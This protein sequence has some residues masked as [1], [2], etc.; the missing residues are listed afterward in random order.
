[1]REDVVADLGTMIDTAESERAL[2]DSVPTPHRGIPYESHQPPVG[3]L[4]LLSGE[5]RRHNAVQVIPTPMPGRDSLP[6]PMRGA[7]RLG[8][9]L[10][11]VANHRLPPLHQ[12]LPIHD[13]GLDVPAVAIVNQRFD[14]I[15]VRRRGHMVEVDDQDVGLG[16]RAQAAEILALDEF[17]AGEGGRVEDVT[18]APGLE[19]ALDD[20]RSTAAQR[21][22][23]MKFMG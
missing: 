18:G 19:I 9:H 1:M 7:L 2:A 3:R 20:A 13:H 8:I 16:A 23:A 5:R 14:R 11:L 17:A 15:M 22:S 4:C 12:R 10:G 21:I 6:G